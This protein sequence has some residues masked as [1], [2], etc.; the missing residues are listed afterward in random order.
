MPE[1]VAIAYRDETVA[2]QAIQELHRGCDELLMEPDAS[3]VLIC[4][5]DGSCRLTTSRRAGASAHWSKFWGVLLGA[6]LGGDDAAAIDPLFRGQVRALLRPGTSM[7]LLA[8]PRVGKQRVLDALSHFG[9]EPLTCELA[10]DLP[11]RWDVR[12]LRFDR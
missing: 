6:L 9:G 7:L 12:G 5:R 1:L 11:G 10:Y 4:E 8:A 3:S 2:D